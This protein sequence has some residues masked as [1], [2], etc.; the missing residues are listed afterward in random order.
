MFCM[1]GINGLVVSLLFDICDYRDYHVSL[2]VCV[3]CS[4][5]LLVSELFAGILFFI[6]Y[7]THRQKNIITTYKHLLNC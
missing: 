1:R 3:L 6:C 5:E 4:P 7:E 2:C